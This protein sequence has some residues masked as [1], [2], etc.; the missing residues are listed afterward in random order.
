MQ[1]MLLATVPML[2]SRNFWMVYGERTSLDIAVVRA[3]A[4]RG[5]LLGTQWTGGVA[6]LLSSRWQA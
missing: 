1:H 2:Y 6:G 3:Y 5:A 4:C